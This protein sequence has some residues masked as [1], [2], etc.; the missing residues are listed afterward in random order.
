MRFDG[1]GDLVARLELRT[2]GSQLLQRSV[3]CSRVF[4]CNFL[5]TATNLVS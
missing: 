2:A 4:Y 1:V 3:R 5:Y